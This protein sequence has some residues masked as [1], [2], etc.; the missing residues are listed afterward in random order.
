MLQFQEECWDALCELSGEEVARLLTDYHGLQLLD[1]GFREFLG[2]EGILPEIE[3]NDEDEDDDDEIEDNCENETYNCNTK[4]K[5]KSKKRKRNGVTYILGRSGNEPKMM[6]K[7]A[8]SSPS[9]TFSVRGHY[10]H[11]KSGKVIW[12]AEFTKG[13]G[14]KKDKTYKVGKRG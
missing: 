2:D 8:H 1:E 4:L 11:Y 7:G 14:K 13:S 5:K 12:I 3:D 10:R 9:G 6:V